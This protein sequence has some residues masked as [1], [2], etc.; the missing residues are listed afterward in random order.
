MLLSSFREQC[1][2]MRAAAII[3]SVI[4][5]SLLAGAA[6]AQPKTPPHE[7]SP[8][9]IYPAGGHPKVVATFPAAGQALPGGVL[10]LTVTFDQQMSPGGF[11][12][13]AQAGGEPLPCLKIPRLLDDGKTFAWLCTTGFG[14]SYALTLNAGAAGGFANVADQRAEA[15]TLAF[16]TTTSTDGPRNVEDAVKQAKLKAFELP[17]QETPGLPAGH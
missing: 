1:A 13:T 7:V 6:A 2:A 11:D 16:T 10:I 3:A 4:C 15:S 17:I 8:V 12:L 5:W 9:T 14:K